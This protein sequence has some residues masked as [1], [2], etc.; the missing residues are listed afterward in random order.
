MKEKNL[1][2]E[3]QDILESFEAGEWQPVKDQQEQAARHRRYAQNTLRK[4]RRVNIRIS[5]KDLDEIQAR[6]V[7]DGIPYQTLMASILHRYV[8]GRLVDAKRQ[9]Q[10]HHDDSDQ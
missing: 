6:A 4:D 5:A 7:E 10:R 3:E 2:N 9:P 8:T 1:D